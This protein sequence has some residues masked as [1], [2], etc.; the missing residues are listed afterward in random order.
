MKLCSLCGRELEE[1]AEVC[2]NCG[3]KCQG[4]NSVRIQVP[5]ES[6]EKDAS[7]VVSPVKTEP[8]KKKKGG[9][10][11]VILIV[12]VIALLATAI[13]AGVL[14]YRWYTNPEQQ[15]LRALDAG[16]YEEAVEI[17]EDEPSVRRSD[18]LEKQLKKRIADIKSGFTDESI[19]YEEAKAKLEAMEDLEVKKLASE[20]KEVRAYVDKLNKSRTNFATAESFF[21]TG[22]YADAIKNYRKVIE[23]DPKYAVSA[24]KLT[25]AVNK[26]RDENLAKAAEY[27]Q[28]QLYTEAIGQLQEALEVI[29]ED[30]K[31][32]EQI[33]IYEKDH[34]EKLK[35]DALQDAQAY[36]EKGDYL[37]AV[38]TLENIIGKL[39]S[40]AEMSSAYNQYSQQYVAGVITEVDGK[41]SQKDFDSAV[42][43]LHSALKNLP[44][45]EVLTNKLK[46]VEAKQ[47]ISITELLAVNTGY[48]E[49]WNS[50]N[51]T[52]PFGNDY[53]GACNYVVFVGYDLLSKNLD[54][55]AEYRLYGKYTMLTGTI[56]T[57]IDS[58]ENKINRLQ[59]FADDKLVYNSPNLGR[60]TDAID[61]SI[62]VSGV[63]YVKI[64]VF[65]EAW[66]KAILSDVQLWP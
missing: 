53:S 25:E 6:G 3:N 42:S 14:Y 59:I 24:E 39:G 1:L 19:T 27:A 33:R 61:F 51:P 32:T 44:G 15:L 17:M 10:A 40:D 47:P 58:P 41:V 2:P 37:N 4:K 5:Q 60:K 13:A 20:L 36:A 34:G 18:A 9:K 62:D 66:A 29:P 55:Y 64:V 11:K 46:E 28:T 38:K 65:T 57:H 52:D 45:N 48:W 8:P 56:A 50:G 49:E 43:S 21:K 26:Y 54:H 35:A 63:E 22:D 16:D 7:A 23:E 30:A 31:I 12:I